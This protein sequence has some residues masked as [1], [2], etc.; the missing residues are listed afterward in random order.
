[1]GERL[2]IQGRIYDRRTI[3]LLDAHDR[4][5]GR[6]LIF[7]YDPTQDAWESSRPDGAARRSPSA[8]WHRRRI[9]IRG[10]RL[11]GGP[12]DHETFVMNGLARISHWADLLPSRDFSA[13]DNDTH[14]R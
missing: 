3:Q 14:L 4:L 12:I 8:R 11:H 9:R 13:I 10:R 7:T 6:E 2:D 1:M 5:V